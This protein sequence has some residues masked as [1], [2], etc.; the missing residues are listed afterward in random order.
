MNEHKI[1]FEVKK[2]FL[3]EFSFKKNSVEKAIE[4]YEKAKDF[5]P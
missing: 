2:L 5:E 3:R 1:C 4:K